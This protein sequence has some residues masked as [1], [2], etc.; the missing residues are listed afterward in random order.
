MSDSDSLAFAARWRDVISQ[1]AEQ[2]VERLRPKQRYATVVSWDRVNRTC[3]VNFAS[4]PDTDIPV[5]MGLIQPSVVGQIVRIGGTSDDRYITDVK[6]A[7]EEITDYLC[8]DG[9]TFTE[10]MKKPVLEGRC[11]K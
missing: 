4:S 10:G 5:A 3:I 7:A 9:K 6:G 11:F 1:I 8:W 2:A